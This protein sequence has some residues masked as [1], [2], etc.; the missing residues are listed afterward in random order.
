LD[1]FERHTDRELWEALEKCHIKGMV[2]ADN[3]S[4]NMTICHV[5]KGNCIAVHGT[6]SHSYGVSLAI[7]DQTM[8]P[9]TRH[10]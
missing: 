5:D 3:L 9:A 2:S 7:W 10:K 6:P 8:L 1:P 4:M